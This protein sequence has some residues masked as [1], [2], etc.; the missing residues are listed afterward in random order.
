MAK[1]N[2]SVFGYFRRK[3]AIKKQQ[4]TV[5]EA[6]AI[7]EAM[8]EG[9]KKAKEE[10]MTKLLENVK[11][12]NEAYESFDDTEGDRGGEEIIKELIEVSKEEILKGE[13]ANG[14]NE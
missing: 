1:N 13:N 14:N 5:E 10:F 6:K 11:E 8:V 7:G 2:K 12:F 9:R 3:N 4:K